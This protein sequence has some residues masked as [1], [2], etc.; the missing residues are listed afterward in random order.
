MKNIYNK[1]DI[2]IGATIRDCYIVKE[3]NNEY[4]LKCNHCGKEM[5]FTYNKI[6]RRQVNFCKCHDEFINNRIGEIWKNSN[7]EIM[8]IIDYKNARNVLIEFQDEYK[9][10]MWVSYNNVKTGKVKN[11]RKRTVNGGYHGKSNYTVANKHQK[12]FS[13]WNKMLQRANDTKYQE[14]HITYKDCKICE[15]W[16]CYANFEQW[17]DNNYYELDDELMNL[18]KDILIKGNKLYSPK[19]CIFVPQRI[20]KLFTKC[21]KNRGDCPLGVKKSYNKFTAMVSFEGDK[22]WLGSYDRIEDAFIAYKQEKEKL[23]KQVADEYKS[24]YPNFPQKLYDAMYNYQV[25]ITD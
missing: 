13:T 16:Y 15:E 24:K 1:S 8:K 18:D 25:E 3:E 9:E 6:R 4:T 23:I 20:N 12:C 14:K 7:G 17:Y 11:P 22:I 19:T 10:T 5:S 21:D 2:Y